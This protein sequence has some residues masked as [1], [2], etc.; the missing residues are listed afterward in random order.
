[1]FVKSRATSATSLPIF[2]EG[3][4]I[5]GRVEVDLDKAES[6]KGVSISILAGTTFVG[7]EED[8]FLKKEESLWTGSKLNG[9][10]SWP[11]T[12]KLPKDVLLKEDTRSE[13]FPL[14][15]H[16]TER[17]SPAYIDY[18]LVVTVKRGFL[19][20]NQTLVT[21]FGYYPLTLPDQPSPL[22]RM[23]YSERSPLIGP[24][25]DQAGWKVLSPIKIKGTL[26]NTK[27]V[28]VN[29]TLAIATPLSYAVGSPIPLSITFT[30]EDTH[31]LDVLAKPTA[32]QLHLRRSMATGT[33]ATDDDGAR[34][35][36]NHFLEDCGTAYF[37]PSQDGAQ[38]TNKRVLEG[39]LELP[40]AL[41]PSFKFPKFTIRVCGFYA[42]KSRQFTNEIP[43]DHS[44]HLIF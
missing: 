2:F 25:G 15:P 21:S 39:E 36:D 8:V 14:P 24:E 27:E 17:A 43:C 20:V 29:C 26:F 31:A 22:R 13:T 28:E 40:K 9:K 7:Q 11:F 37:W 16:F 44:I 12:F 18:R 19:K 3:D 23:A 33:E 34:R 10:Y 30:A 38:E 4:T 32:I 5:S 6:S 41:K 42:L 35:T 1:M